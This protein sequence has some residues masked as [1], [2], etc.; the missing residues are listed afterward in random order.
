MKARKIG[1]YL[2]FKKEYIDKILRGEKTTTIRRGILSPSHD[3]VYLESDGKIYGEL[4]LKS[5][6]YTKIS[7]LRDSDAVADGFKDLK[8]LK[9]VLSSIYPGIKEDEWVTI[10]KFK[11]LMTLEKPIQKADKVVLS[12][13]EIYKISRFVLAYDFPNNF[14][15]KR[16]FSALIYTR[17]N[18]EK[19]LAELGE[20]FSREEIIEILKRYSKKLK[21]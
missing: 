16:I 15:E 11:P 8:E 20:D 4:V 2:R 14:R 6:R 18:I 10:I 3:V 1:K 13:D 5:V 7:K 17:G 9:S 19:A 12:E 21:F